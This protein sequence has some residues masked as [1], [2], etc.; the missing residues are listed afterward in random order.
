MHAILRIKIYKV[1]AIITKYKT[2]KPMQE[3]DSEMFFVTC[4]HCGQLQGNRVERC[5]RCGYGLLYSQDESLIKKLR[6]VHDKNEQRQSLKDKR[7]RQQRRYLN[8]QY[9]RSTSLETL[10]C[11]IGILAVSIIGFYRA[12]LLSISDSKQFKTYTRKDVHKKIITK[13]K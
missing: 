9:R 7:K 13:N 3:E 8:Q 4:H 6:D 12:G 1:S 10:I 11:I 5:R 2:N